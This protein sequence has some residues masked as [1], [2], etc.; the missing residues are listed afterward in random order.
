M[1]DFLFYLHSEKINFFPI[2]MHGHLNHNVVSYGEHV[3][4]NI[5]QKGNN[6]C[7]VEKENVSASEM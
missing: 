5:I 3:I 4:D 7:P 1:A 6:V 2:K